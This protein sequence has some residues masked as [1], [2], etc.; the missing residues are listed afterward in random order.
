MSH[1]AARSDFVDVVKY[2]GDFRKNYGL[3]IGAVFLRGR[4]P[5]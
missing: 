4:P 2:N 3:I 1:L 5:C